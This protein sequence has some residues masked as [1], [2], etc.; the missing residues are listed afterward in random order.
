MKKLILA[1]AFTVALGACSQAAEDSD[2]VAPAETTAAATEAAAAAPSS[3]A[4]TY[5]VT[6]KDGTKF[7]STLNPDGTYQDTDAAGKVTEKGMW[8]DHDGKTCFDPEGDETS[9]QCFT[10]TEP[11]A[12]GTF[13]AT[14]DDGAT[15]LTIRKTA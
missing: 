11:D 14:S 5:E 13:T 1:A 7:T 8:A 6:T 4:G 9:G 15:K 10:T 2:E 3:S 12:Q